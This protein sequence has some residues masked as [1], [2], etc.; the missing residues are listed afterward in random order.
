[1]DR[2]LALAIAAE[3][4]ASPGRVQHIRSLPLQQAVQAI[5]QLKADVKKAVKR[6]ALKYHPDRNPDRVEW[7]TE[8]FKVLMAVVAEI[9]GL[10]VVARQPPPI[11]RTVQWT[12]TSATSTA[13]T[14]N[15]HGGYFRWVTQP[16]RPAP[17]A[18]YDAT[19]V[20]FIRVV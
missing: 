16:A 11:Q 5:E 6:L 7:A 1:M 3:L 18:N 12:H 10:R 2:Q 13:T 14:V 8:R 15:F 4:G 19:R 9:E 20:V 17:G